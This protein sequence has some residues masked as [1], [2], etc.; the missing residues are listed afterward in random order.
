MKIANEYSGTKAAARALLLAAGSFFSQGNYSESQARFEEFLNKYRDHPM[1]SQALL[2]VAATF[3]AQ[4]NN[5]L[6]IA[7]YEEVR[8]VYPSQ[9]ASDIAHLALARLYDAENRW[10]DAYAIYEEIVTTHSGSGMG[11]EAGMRMEDLKERH[12]ELVQ[13]NTAPISALTAPGAISRTNLPMTLDLE[14]TNT[15]ATPPPSTTPPNP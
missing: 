15:P 2:G 14:L 1:A 9:P 12:P 4:K 10:E 3:D 6:A 13:T 8:R 11:A 5:P 7:K